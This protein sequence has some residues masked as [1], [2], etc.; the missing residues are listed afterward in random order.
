[1][2]ARRPGRQALYPTNAPTR[3][4][5]GHGQRAAGP[6]LHDAARGGG[7][8]ATATRIDRTRSPNELDPAAGHGPPAMIVPLAAPPM[9]KAH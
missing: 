5:T 1:V 4:V 6:R 9:P 7:G 8:A 3:A 2:P